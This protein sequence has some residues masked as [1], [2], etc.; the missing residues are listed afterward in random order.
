[1]T[2]TGRSDRNLTYEK[3]ARDISQCREKAYGL[4]KSPKRRTASVKRDRYQAPGKSSRELNTI[5][6]TAL[7]T[8]DS[9]ANIGEDNKSEESLSQD[10]QVQE[11]K[12]NIDY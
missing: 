12:L 7:N 3:Q 10:D 6:F 1:M 5:M 2:V 11:D 8:L 9:E 4:I